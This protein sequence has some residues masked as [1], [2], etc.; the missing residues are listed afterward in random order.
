MF[1]SWI[2]LLFQNKII[3]SYHNPQSNFCRWATEARRESGDQ[4]QMQLK[5][6]WSS[7]DDSFIVSV[8]SVFT[9]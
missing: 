3:Q 4:I 7:A 5:K 1:K 2:L 6:H 8:S 9:D